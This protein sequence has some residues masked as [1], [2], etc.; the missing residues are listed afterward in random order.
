[1]AKRR[2][3]AANEAEKRPYVSYPL[4][5]IL[6]IEVWHEERNLLSASVQPEEDTEVVRGKPG[7]NNSALLPLWFLVAKAS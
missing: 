2:A 1:M 4:Y 5:G 6:L 3:R 7:K